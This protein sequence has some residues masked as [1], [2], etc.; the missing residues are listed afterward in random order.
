MN[1]PFKLYILLLIIR[2]QNLYDSNS[3]AKVE[4][5]LY[6]NIYINIIL[7]RNLGRFW[8]LLSHLKNQRK[9]KMT[10]EWDIFEKIL[11]TPI[12]DKPV[13]ICNNDQNF[14]FL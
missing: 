1:F 14:T 10:D 9:N 2:Q 4:E 12:N 7:I 13:E 6:K 8:F 5:G 3:V 11:L